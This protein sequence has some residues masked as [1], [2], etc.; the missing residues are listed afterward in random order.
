MTILL[1]FRY[2]LIN[3][4]FKI[5]NNEKSHLI[6]HLKNTKLK[7]IIVIF[8]INSDQKY[9]YFHFDLS[10]HRKVEK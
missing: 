5:L 10:K 6:Y 9:I 3:I 8:N 7:K 4:I 1:Y 2:D